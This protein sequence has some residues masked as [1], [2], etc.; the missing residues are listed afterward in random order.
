MRKLTKAQKRKSKPKEPSPWRKKKKGYWKRVDLWYRIEPGFDKDVL[1]DDLRRN[2]IILRKN[3][4]T[5]I[6]DGYR[7]GITIKEGLVSVSGQYAI[8]GDPKAKPV[9]VSALGRRIA[10][11]LKRG[12]R[13]LPKPSGQRY[14]T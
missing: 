14:L 13:S 10:T 9:G 1:I 4:Q 12:V 2:G 8:F 3:D 5:P 7:V 11:D 6:K